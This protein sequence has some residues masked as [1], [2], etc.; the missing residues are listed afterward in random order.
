MTAADAAGAAG[1]AGVFPGAGPVHPVTLSPSALAESATLPDPFELLADWLPANDD[2]A[3]PL[4][5][6]GTVS[7]DG[8]PDART[9]LLS[10][11][12]E[13]GLHLHTD[14]RSR[15][16]GDLAATPRA[17]LTLV[18]PGRQIVVQ[19]VVSRVRAEQEHAAY[20]RRSRYL[21]LLAWLNTD[22]FAA[23][24]LEERLAAWAAYGEEH[25]SLAAPET[26][27]G[28]VVE[29]VR[30]TFWEGRPETAGI[31]T[32]FRRD[33]LEAAWSVTTLAG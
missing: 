9:V 4:M 23:L 16:V 6:L 1:A 32:E 30:L 5:T 18:W 26:W 11:F 31:R 28:F 19:G 2:P 25:P 21:Q 13:R 12:D 17:S 29:P 24:P 14:S 33:G 15:K 7:P 10:E 3:R 27:V 20:A 8:F 22:E